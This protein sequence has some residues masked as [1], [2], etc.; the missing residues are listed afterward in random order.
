MIPPIAPPTD[1]GGSTRLTAWTVT[2]VDDMIDT[3]ESIQVAAD[4]QTHFL[5]VM[6]AAL[7]F[8]VLIEGIKLGYAISHYFLPNATD[9]GAKF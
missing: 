6:T 1:G 7:Y 4:N 3:I 9:I 8:L 2:V 5:E